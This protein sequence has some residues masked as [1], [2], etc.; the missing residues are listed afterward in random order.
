LE[1]FGS[2][3][4]MPAEPVA[5]VRGGHDVSTGGVFRQQWYY[6]YGSIWMI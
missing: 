2:L 5:D 3:L 4:S 6:L 1:R